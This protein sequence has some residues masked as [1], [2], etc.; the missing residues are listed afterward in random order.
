MLGLLIPYRC[1]KSRDAK[2]G[3][4]SGISYQRGSRNPRPSDA[5]AFWRRYS[6]KVAS[7]RVTS[8]ID[9]CSFAV[10][11]A[12]QNE[13]SICV[14]S[15]PI[16]ARNTPRSRCSSADHQRSSDLSPNASASLIASRDSVV[17]PARCKTSAFRTRKY[18]YR[19][20]CPIVCYSVL[21]PRDA[22]ICI[23][24]SAARPTAKNGSDRQPKCKILTR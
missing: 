9:F 6:A 21:D 11:I 19:T 3:C 17:R 8:E 16:A 15:A 24:G 13:A 18:G 14:S 7:A 12:A 23:T 10:L 5:P 1:K 20:G 2:D 22:F 4:L